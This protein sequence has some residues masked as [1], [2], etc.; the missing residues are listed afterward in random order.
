[1]LKIEDFD[2]RIYVQSA[3]ERSPKLFM[4]KGGCHMITVDYME[5]LGVKK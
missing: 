2:V 5:G 3:F 1:M 4:K